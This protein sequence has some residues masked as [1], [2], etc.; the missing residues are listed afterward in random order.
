MALVFDPDG[1]DRHAGLA[2]SL[3]FGK[4]INLM[5]TSRD[6]FYPDPRSDFTYGDPRARRNVVWYE[7]FSS[8]IG[9]EVRE[10]LRRAV[11]R[12]LETSRARIVFRAAP[13][14]DDPQAE[15]KARGMIAAGWQNA[16][17]LMS[18]RLTNVTG[19][20]SDADM[21]DIARELELDVDLFEQDLRSEQTTERLA[22]DSALAREA[23]AALIIDGAP[24][25]G[26]LDESSLTDA[27]EKPFGYRLRTVTEAFFHWAAAGGLVL[28]L[29][30]LAALAVANFGL[31]ESYEH[32]R[33]SVISLGWNDAHFGLSVE[34]W[35]NDGLMALFFLIVG[36]EI[37][38]EI[39]SGEL[40]NIR[41]AALP[42]AG[43][44]GGMVVPALIYI[45][46]A[47]GSDAA[48]GWGIPMA[49]DIAFSLGLMALLGRRVP[50]S[51]R[52][53]L[54]ALAIVDDLGAIIV[55]ALFYSSG[56]VWG[57][58]IVA[59]ILLAIMWGL[60][61]ARIYALWIYLVFGVLLWI[62]IFAGGLHATLAGV[63]TAV[64]IPS[65]R[66]AAA[67]GVAL[68][69]RAI[70]ASEIDGVGALDSFADQTVERLSQ[71]VER[72]R[73]P[74]RHLQL[75]LETWTSF[76][77][78]PLFAFFNTGLVLWGSGV[79]LTAPAEAGVIAG[80]I[81]GK[82]V[83]IIMASAIALRL[84]LA[85]KSVDITWRHLIGAGCLGGIGF[86]MSIFIASS[87][88][89][90]ATL[91]SVKISILIASLVSGLLGMAILWGAPPARRNQDAP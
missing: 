90:G 7:S 47:G 70:L 79:D 36:I 52:V 2:Q 28:I 51:L 57:P 85:T 53:F 1:R 75:R 25:R 67:H 23:R 8:E 62:A 66:P 60:N 16:D 13:T 35:V 69:T 56:V 76:L 33:H 83:G 32:L 41:Q 45:S 91:A 3:L 61:R 63:L 10:L 27:L 87:A 30:T 5:S 37:K 48:H 24:Y 22:E 72:L 77:V 64:M 68:Q 20:V 18:A 80:L 50:L 19:L 73:E 31:F 26:V 74:G 78:L 4:G 65:R 29:A 88:F 44:L 81:V 71:V 34:H 43:A 86:T 21:I 12:A 42:I 55:I 89:V 54:S 11:R 49:T 14:T 39:V 9:P 59:A 40:S 82:P 6:P 46:F 58:L 17:R 38:H 84:G 15:I